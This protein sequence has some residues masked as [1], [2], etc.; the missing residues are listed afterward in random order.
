MYLLLLKYVFS[1]NTCESGVSLGELKIGYF[2]PHSAFTTKYQVS[3]YQC[4]I[5]CHLRIK[6]CKSFNYRRSALSCQLC[7][8]DSG[9]GGNNLQPKAG[10]IHSNIDTWKNLPIGPC[11]SI[12]CSWT[13]RCDSSKNAVETICVPTECPFAELKLGMTIEPS[14]ETSVS[15]KARRRCRSHDMERA[16]SNSCDTGYINISLGGL[17]FCIKSYSN[18]T[19]FDK[20]MEICESEKAKLLIITTRDQI[21]DINAYLL[22]G[23]TYA[24][25]S[26]KHEEGTW[27][28]W[29]GGVVE[30][31]WYA[32]EPSGTRAENCGFI[33]SNISGLLDNP[34]DNNYYFI[35]SKSYYVVH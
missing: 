2:L 7:E 21:A 27:V 18:R 33:A 25:I 22:D 8:K 19:T 20:A 35:C 30:P 6:R 1:S 9:P 11:T 14:N 12:N 15:T 13:E 3:A 34:C 28:G 17:F 31:S 32:G 5:E 4:A 26:D 10:S 29:D 16:P 23:W 24:G